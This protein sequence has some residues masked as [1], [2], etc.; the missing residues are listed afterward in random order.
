MTTRM[1]KR[2]TALVL[3]GGG[4]RGAFEAGAWKALREKGIDFHMVTGTSV[5][6][7]NGTMAALDDYETAEKMWL[8]LGTEDLFDIDPTDNLLPNSFDMSLKGLPQS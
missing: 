1:T 7:I 8:T 6:A 2:K 5:G 4:G 3:S